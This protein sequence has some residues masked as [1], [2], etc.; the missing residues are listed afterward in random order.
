[1]ATV[2]RPGVPIERLPD[3]HIRTHQVCIRCG[4]G[5]G[6]HNYALETTFGSGLR[7]IMA[8]CDACL[9]LIGVWMIGQGREVSNTV[10]PPVDGTVVMVELTYD[11]GLVEPDKAIRDFMA[12]RNRTMQDVQDFAYTEKTHSNGRVEKYYR[13][14]MPVMGSD[15]IALYRLARGGLVRDVRFYLDVAPE[16]GR[17]A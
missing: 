6:V 3:D 1:M 13:I 4:T 15:F 9:S 8:Y 16:T 2:E 12:L 17:D 11:V 14:V 10:V 7:Q 5:D